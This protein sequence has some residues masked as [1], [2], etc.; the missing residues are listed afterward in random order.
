MIVSAFDKSL[1]RSIG[2]GGIDLPKP[3]QPIVYVS[4]G[5]LKKL[6]PM[7]KSKKKS[8]PLVI[9]LI[10]GILIVVN[11]III[12]FV[13]RDSDDDSTQEV[14]QIAEVD[15]VIDEVERQG[16]GKEAATERRPQLVEPEIDEAIGTAP[17]QPSS[18]QVNVDVEPKSAQIEIDG[19]TMGTGSMS[20]SY[21][22]DGRTHEMRVYA[23]GHEEFRTTFKDNAPEE[24]IVLLESPRKRSASYRKSRRPRIKS[25]DDLDVTSVKVKPKTTKTTVSKPAV[26]KPVRQPRFDEGGDSDNLDPWKD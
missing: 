13:A 23:E 24:K 26:D 15:D 10:A 8:N 12:F 6:K 22:E 18:F 2:L 14:S 11:V 25:R 17:S 1:V 19:D 5:F 20:K 16:Q 3:A 21:A 7:R 9:V 4:P